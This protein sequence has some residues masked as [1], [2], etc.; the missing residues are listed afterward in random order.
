MFLPHEHLW[1]L[2]RY[3]LLRELG[4]LLLV[5]D[6]IQ[7]EAHHN[8]QQ[9]LEEAKGQSEDESGDGGHSVRQ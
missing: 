5:H 3:L 9:R 1:Q 7:R 2:Q 4:R 8:E 6:S